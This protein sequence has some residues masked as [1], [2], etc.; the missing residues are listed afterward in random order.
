MELLFAQI[1]LLPRYQQVIYCLSCEMAS[2]LPEVCLSEPKLVISYGDIWDWSYSWSSKS[3]LDP[4]RGFQ[5]AHTS[6]RQWLHCSHTKELW[7]EAG[8]GVSRPLGCSLAPPEE[9]PR[10]NDAAQHMQPWLCCSQVSQEWI[11][12]K[13]E[14]LQGNLHTELLVAGK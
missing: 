14:S 11:K 1:A 6:T 4:R 2:L 13:V 10:R 3:H 9:I 12:D 8:C 5:A 7:G